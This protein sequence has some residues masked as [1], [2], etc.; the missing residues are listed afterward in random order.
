MV[1]DF[2]KAGILIVDDMAPMLTL[3]AS[4]LK[5]FGFER[6]W[7]AR[8]PEQ[9]LEL[10]CEHNPD[11][12]LTDWLMEPYDGIEFARK[13]RTDKRVPNKFVPIVMMT[14]YSHRIRVEQARD[15]GITE[16]LV[17][18]F[19]A[20]DL[21]MRIEQLIEKPRRFVRNE[22]FFGPDRRRRKKTDGPQQVRRDSDQPPEGGDK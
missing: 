6:I 1:Y 2:K 14:G 17:K 20:K 12:V 15:M 7:Q 9:G 4:L 19:K 10:L 13:I 3:T 8:D 11:I 5:E 18:P 22:D 21:Y 16:F